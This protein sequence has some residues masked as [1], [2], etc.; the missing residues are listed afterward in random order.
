MS[1]LF[2]GEI[3]FLDIR[4]YLKIDS[5]FHQ[6]L[7]LSSKSLK[8]CVG[9]SPLF[10]SLSFSLSFFLPLSLSLFGSYKPFCSFEYIGGKRCNT[11]LSRKL[12]VR[13]FQSSPC[14]LSRF[15][16][17]YWKTSDLQSRVIRIIWRLV[18]VR[19]ILQ[20]RKEF[21]SERTHFRLIWTIFI[22]LLRVP[23][24]GASVYAVCTL[25]YM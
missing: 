11:K 25:A 9:K 14:G 13:N 12:N 4:I 24:P 15:K 3:G 1:G 2:A 19:W 10:S 20:K 22:V 7:S 17:T 23:T 6:I 16:N 21:L 8:A 5:E 18:R